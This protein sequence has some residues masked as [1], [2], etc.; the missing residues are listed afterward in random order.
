MGPRPRGSG[1]AA[2]RRLA[3]DACRGWAGLYTSFTEIAP[4]GRPPGAT[5]FLADAWRERGLGDF[6]SYT[7]VAEGAAEAMVEVELC[8]WDAAA[9]CLLVEEA[10]GR[11]AELGPPAPIGSHS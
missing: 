10:G 7:L 5:R 9:P 3:V 8:L 1:A 4:S 2:D 11:A 6:W